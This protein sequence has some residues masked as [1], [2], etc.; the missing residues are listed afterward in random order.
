MASSSTTM[1]HEL[2]TSRDFVKL[3]E[4]NDRH[5]DEVVRKETNLVIVGFYQTILNVYEM[6]KDRRCFKAIVSS[7]GIDGPEEELFEEYI[8]ELSTQI[9]IGVDNTF[10]LFDDLRRNDLWNE[11]NF[12]DRQAASIK[13]LSDLCSLALKECAERDETQS[14]DE[15]DKKQTA[16]RNIFL[17]LIELTYPPS[18]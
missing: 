7:E 5:I 2:G 3:T 10:A 13:G 6:G 15:L 12:S 8:A 4:E 11:G 14:I 18:E 17:N 9:A 1:N 16:R